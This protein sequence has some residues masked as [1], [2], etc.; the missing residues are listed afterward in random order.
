M[1]TGTDMNGKRICKVVFKDKSMA[2]CH[3]LAYG[4]NFGDEIGIAIATKLLENHFQCN[5]EQ[6]PVINL[7][8]SHDRAGK[9]CLFN[10]GSI[11]HMLHPNDHVWGTGINPKWQSQT[12]PSNITYHAVRGVLTREKVQPTLK[13]GETLLPIGDPGSATIKLYQPQ[14]KW[15][16]DGR[17]CFV[18]HHQD[19]ELFLKNQ[20]IYD[21]LRHIRMVSVRNTWKNVTKALSTCSTVAS[22]SL[23]GLVIADALGIPNRWFQY[24]GG[25]TEKTEGYFKYQDYFSTIQRHDATPMRELGDLFNISKYWNRLDSSIMTSLINGIETSFPYDLFETEDSV[26]ETS[27]DFQS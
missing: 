12:F 8:A 2:L 13:E 25:K 4:R 16:S 6:V 20:D 23:H 3:F 21:E 7:A 27:T 26:P 14:F 19:Q 15:D 17:P 11:H 1:I 5:S 24:S 10:L 18:P 9:I 22:S